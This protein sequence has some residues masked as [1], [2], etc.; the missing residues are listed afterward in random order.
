MKTQ[1]SPLIILASLFSFMYSY[2]SH[3]N[4]APLSSCYTCSTWRSRNIY[5]KLFFW[6]LISKFLYKPYIRIN[7]PVNKPTYSIIDYIMIINHI[8]NNTRILNAHCLQKIDWK[9][10]SQR[11]KKIKSAKIPDVHPNCN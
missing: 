5:Q 9:N 8:I 2:T 1:L 11:C 3:C 10:F 7:F 6:A 4:L